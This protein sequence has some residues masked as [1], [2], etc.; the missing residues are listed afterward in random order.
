M[1]LSEEHQKTLKELCK[2]NNQ[3]YFQ[4]DT[5]GISSNDKSMFCYYDWKNT[6]TNEFGVFDVGEFLQVVSLYKKPT[7]T[8]GKESLTITDGKQKTT[9]RYTAKNVI[10]GPGEKKRFFDGDEALLKKPYATFT[11]KKEDLDYLQKQAAILKL[12]QLKFEKKSIT[13]FVQNN[14]STNTFTLDIE[15]TADITRT[16]I[17][18]EN[19]QKIMN[20]DY[21]VE[22]CKGNSMDGSESDYLVL[23]NANLTYIIC[24]VDE[25]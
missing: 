7:I 10:I 2:I 24:P 21:T 15:P 14:T 23:K 22:I 3:I 20:D 1:V 6:V 19:L 17:D 9:Y 12:T 25:V 8:E 4:S 13:A 5:L 16:I 11:L 18:N